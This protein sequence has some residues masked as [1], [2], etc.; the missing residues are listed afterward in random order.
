[1]EPIPIV[2]NE[3]AAAEALKSNDQK[4]NCGD[5]YNE[6]G[7]MS[8]STTTLGVDSSM[9]RVRYTEV[10]SMQIFFCVLCATCIMFLFY[11]A[12]LSCHQ[13][14]T[15]FLW[16]FVLFAGNVMLSFNSGM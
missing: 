16:L 9:I 14:V 5:A 1:M 7:R 8:S 11:L 6:E 2:V 4:E 15:C 13:R 10:F 12:L 3:E